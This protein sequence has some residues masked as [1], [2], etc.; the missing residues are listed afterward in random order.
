MSNGKIIRRLPSLVELKSTASDNLIKL[1]EKYKRLI[2]ADK[3]PVELSQPLSSLV[4]QLKHK[5]TQNEIL[6]LE[7]N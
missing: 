6:D 2:N 3:Y 1:P 4:E 5:I 7:F